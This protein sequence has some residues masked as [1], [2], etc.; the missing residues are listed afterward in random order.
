[1]KSNLDE[2]WEKATLPEIEK[3]EGEHTVSI[4]SGFGWFPAKFVKTWTKVICRPSTTKGDWFRITRGYNLVNKKITGEFTVFGDLKNKCLELFYDL[5]TNRRF[6]RRCNDR[7]RRVDEKTL[8]GQVYFRFWHKHKFA[9][10][11]IL[12]KKEN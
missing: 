4:S 6:W 7:I 5:P 9:G 10:Y 3:L 11:F 8:I 12:E 2:M 1:M